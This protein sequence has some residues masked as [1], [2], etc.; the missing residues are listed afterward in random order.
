MNFLLKR[1]EMYV[2]MSEAA[3]N[4]IRGIIFMNTRHILF[5]T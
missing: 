4:M 5:N 3:F 1:L 2:L